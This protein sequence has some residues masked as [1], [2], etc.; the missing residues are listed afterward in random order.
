M[1]YWKQPQHFDSWTAPYDPTDLVKDV[2]N[3]SA[4]T[5]NGKLDLNGDTKND[6]L[7]DALNYNGGS[8]TTGAAR[9]LLRQAVASLLNAASAQVDYPLSVST[10]RNQ[11]NTALAS[12]KRETL[13]KLAKQLD[14][15]NNERCLLN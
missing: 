3:V 8:G 9:N 1:G 5:A 13:L 4:F 7:L 15:L 6:T 12:N 11:V 14:E 10:V 2:F